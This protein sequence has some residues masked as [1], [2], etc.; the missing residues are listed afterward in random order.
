MSFI[1]N[2]KAVALAMMV[3]LSGCGQKAENVSLKDRILQ[4]KNMDKVE[5]MALDLVKGGFNA[6]SSYSEVWIRD[7]NTFIELSMEVMPD[8]LIRK[9]LDL[10]FAFQGPTG[11]IVDGFVPISKA[12]L[13][14]KDGYKYRLSK[15]APDYAAHKNTVETDHETSLVQAV[16]KYVR[17]SGNKDYLKHTIGDKTV[18]DRLCWAMEYLMKEKTDA[19]YGLLTGATTADWGDVQHAHP[20]GV[21]IDEDTR[22]TIDIYDN[23][24]FV[25]ALNDLIDLSDSE[26][27]KKKWTEVRDRIAEN[28]NTH[29]WDKQN[30]KYI[31]HVYLTESPFS[32]FDENKIYYHGGTA[33]AVL[34]GLLSEE[35][36]AHANDRML[37]NQRAAHA[38]TIGLT[39]YPTYPAGAFENK[40]MYPYGYQ[41][42]G[43][44]TWFGARM[45]HGLVKYGMMEE[46]Y[47]ELEP[48]LTRVIENQSFNE[49]Y[50]PAG[51][52]MGSGTF[53]GEAGVL[54][55][56]I[57]LMRDWAKNN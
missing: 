10:F 45:I 36:V 2:G 21:E 27:D 39:M 26:A 52:P 3:A 5:Q 11:D 7:Y 18:Y 25:L 47:T 40:G 8:S 33:V 32:G 44:W 51:E 55:T 53:R 16:A 13:N 34:A 29:L 15:L 46:A 35:E 57:Q 50:T 9:N 41:N 49:W 42:G 30:R 28:T 14:N 19:K 43:D 24:M 12:D 4:D 38:Q 31:P 17:K 22:Y 6:G 54:Y 23:A 37:A 48:M 20:W 56:A 1:G